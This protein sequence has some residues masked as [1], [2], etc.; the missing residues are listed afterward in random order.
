MTK[1]IFIRDILP[2]FITT[3][4]SIS[5]LKRAIKWNKMDIF[6]FSFKEIEFISRSFADEFLSFMEENKLNYSIFDA[7]ENIEAMFEAAKKTRTNT[8]DRY[9]DHVAITTFK[10]KQDLNQFLSAI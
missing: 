1:T 3:R 8:N 9:N 7:N 4:K 5:R 10:D 6:H 2:S